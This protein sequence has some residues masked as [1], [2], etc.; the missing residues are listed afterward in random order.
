M[1]KLSAVVMIVLAIPAFA[2]AQHRGGMAGPV[3]AA[4]FRG[5]AA[6]SRAASASARSTMRVPSGTQG[7]ARI[8]APALRTRSNGVRIIHRNN[9]NPFGFDGT[10]FEDVPGLGFDFRTWPLSVATAA[11]TATDFS[12]AAFCRA[13]RSS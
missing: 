9:S 11:C 5:G 7:A 2:A 10:D 4:P 8:G 3:M 13:R 1:G 6:I 12:T